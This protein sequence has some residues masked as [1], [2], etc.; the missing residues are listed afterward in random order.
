MN[1]YILDEN[2]EP[3]SCPDILTW[4]QWMHSADRAVLKT[5]VGD[6]HISTVFLGLDHSFYGGPPVLWETMI[7][8]GAFDQDQWRYTSQL[9]AM[10]G[11][12]R[13]VALVEGNTADPTP[14]PL[15]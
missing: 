8:G 13:A 14:D 6:V 9:D 1:T 2:G 5:D 12:A 11:H 3:Q 4:G 10:R 7:F 15:P